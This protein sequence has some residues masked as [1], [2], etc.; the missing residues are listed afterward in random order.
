MGEFGSTPNFLVYNL[1]TKF[2][3]AFY[4]LN[5]IH[6]PLGLVNCLMTPVSSNSV[7]TETASAAFVEDAEIA[8]P[9]SQVVK[10]CKQELGA[11]LG[12][13]LC[14]PAISLD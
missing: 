2:K 3:L 8:E 4:I 10:N 7:E 13:E 11:E 9:S 5:L 14:D 1:M 12:C 6:N